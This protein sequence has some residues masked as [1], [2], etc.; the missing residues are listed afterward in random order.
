MAF[1]LEVEDSK[2]YNSLKESNWSHLKEVFYEIKPWSE[3]FSVPRRTTWV[4]LIGVP[5]I[6]GTIKLSGA[7]QNYVG[8]D[9]MM[10][11]VS[12]SQLDKI[13]SVIELEAGNEFSNLCSRVPVN[14]PMKEIPLGP[15]VLGVAMNSMMS[16][17]EMK[18]Q[19]LTI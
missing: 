4:E 17:L 3:S 7:L 18:K 1:L 10:I 14:F 9:R 5:S 15:R 16:V 11:L 8:A 2:L 19:A 13:D 12:T 6:A